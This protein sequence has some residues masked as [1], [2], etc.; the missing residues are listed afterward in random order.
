MLKPLDL[1]LF[2]PDI[3]SE[4]LVEKYCIFYTIRKDDFTFF[5][6][7]YLEEIGEGDDEAIVTIFKN[8]EKLPSY[9]GSLKQAI[10]EIN[11]LIN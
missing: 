5:L 2:K 4:E 8:K 1:L 9:A 11:Y 7:Y 10:I 6:T 3:I